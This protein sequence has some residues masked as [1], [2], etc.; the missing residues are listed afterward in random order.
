MKVTVNSITGFEDAFVSMY[1]SKRS[2]TPEIDKEIR[3]VCENVLDSRGHIKTWTCDKSKLEQF[4][5]WLDMLLKMG[6][7]HI[8]V[9]R[10]IDI[11]IMT[12]NIHRGAQ[13]DIDSHA[14]RF[15]NRIIRSST[16]LAEYSDNEMSDYYKDKIIP[17]DEALKA[18]GIETP[19]IIK[20]NG[21]KYIKT[22]NGY[23]KEDF[24]NS[25]DVKRGLYMLS[26][27]SNFISKITLCEWGHVFKERN[28]DGG[29]NPEVKEWAETVMKQITNMHNQ[30]TRGYVLTIEN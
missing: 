15:D 21:E 9:L 6:K 10:Y 16:R 5:K 29:A 26:I 25:K 17:T 27:P 19:D 3:E 22:V 30:I 24:I 18:L 2:W 1:I 8:T 20:R 7:R 11:S 4:N 12:E 28:E 14:K 23:I 13:D